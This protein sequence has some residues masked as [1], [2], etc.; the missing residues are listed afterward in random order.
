MAEG[1]PEDHVTMWHPITQRVLKGKRGPQRKR[2]R[3]FCQ[4]R[5]PE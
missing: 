4:V 3:A 2:L 5:V 1:D